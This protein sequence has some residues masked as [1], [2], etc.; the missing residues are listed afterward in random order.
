MVEP[1]LWKI[2]LRQLGLL[3][4]MYGKIKNAPNHQL[5]TLKTLQTSKHVVVQHLYMYAITHRQHK[6]PMQSLSPVSIII[7][8]CTFAIDRQQHNPISPFYHTV[9]HIQNIHFGLNVP[10]QKSIPFTHLAKVYGTIFFRTTAA[11][12]WVPLQSASLLLAPASWNGFVGDSKS[13]VSS[14]AMTNWNRYI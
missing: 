11:L 7:L 12:S 5:G 13:S 10:I 3:F 14:M 6:Y 9:H 8:Y 1:P 4:P 2:W